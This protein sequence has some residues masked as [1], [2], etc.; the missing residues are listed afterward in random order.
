[1]MLPT[2]QIPPPLRPTAA[3]VLP[4]A[5]AAELEE[6]S[7]QPAAQLSAIG[8]FI[9]GPDIPS[10]TVDTI[11]RI[12]TDPDHLAEIAQQS[13]AHPNGFD[14]IPLENRH[15]SYRVRLHVWWPEA[16]L[17]TEDVHNHAW[18][19]ASRV[20]SGDL[21]FQTYRASNTGQRYFHYPWRIGDRGTYDGGAV[22][23]VNL[24]IVLNACFT[25]N[26]HYTF[27]LDEIHR[28][29]PVKTERPVGTLVVLGKMQRD[30]SDVYTENARHGA[31]YRLLKDPYSPGRLAD[32][33][34][35]YLEFL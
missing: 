13:F 24:A 16:E 28:V 15:P 2:H 3:K 21:K 19:F 14:C 6:L 1:M 11:Q 18:S 5:V 22:K 9:A 4:P 26:M 25:E 7:Q 27:D 32:R 34:H 10:W 20:L 30:G 35:R 12:L 8:E 23:T 29:A 31:G 33:L 17:V